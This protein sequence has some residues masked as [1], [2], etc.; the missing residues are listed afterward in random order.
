MIHLRK[1]K[2]LRKKKSLGS[3]NPLKKLPTKEKVV[4][5]GKRKLSRDKKPAKKS[6]PDV[7]T[8]E[9]STEE[10]PVILPSI[11][12]TSSVGSPTSPNSKNNDNKDMLLRSRSR[13][14]Q[15]GPAISATPEDIQEINK[16]IEELQNKIADKEEQLSNVLV[17]KIK[18]DTVVNKLNMDVRA[19]HLLI[20]SLQK[21]S[22]YH[23]QNREKLVTGNSLFAKHQ[24]K[25]KGMKDQ[26]NTLNKE[27]EE[28]KKRNNLTRR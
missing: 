26:L 15:Y 17:D 16:Q 24:K 2:T 3:K 21:E 20:E 8:V 19:T 22:L 27:N 6:Q 23:T 1:K 11:S 13:K 5:A 12:S 14:S 10:E 7:E 18:V 4:T 28:L 9:C 25:L